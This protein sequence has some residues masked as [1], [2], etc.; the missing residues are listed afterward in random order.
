MGV[1]EDVELYGTKEAMTIWNRGDEDYA[2]AVDELIAESKLPS[3]KWVAG[4]APMPPLPAL[5]EHG[6]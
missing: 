3:W 1:I 4:E 2:A 6:R 5:P